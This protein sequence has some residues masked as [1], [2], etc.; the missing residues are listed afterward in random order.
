[1]VESVE[2]YTV[3]G[4]T[5]S[6]FTG[7]LEAYF[8]AKGLPYRF[9]EMDM[10]DF[11]KCAKATGIAQ[12]PQ[13]ETPQGAWLTDTTAIIKRL[14]EEATGPRLH[15]TDPATRFLS[16]LLEDLFDE[17]YWRPALYYRWAFDQDMQLMSS[18]IANTLL[19]DMPLPFFFRR[20]FILR[21]QR[22]V[23]LKQDGVTRT[24]APHI[25]AL[26]LNALKVL[27][28]VFKKRPFLLGDR[29]C[30]ADFGLMGPFFRHFF[31]DPTPAWIMRREA[32]H[33]AHWVTRMWAL[34]P[35]DIK[36]ASEIETIPDD[37]GYFFDLFGNEY[38]PYLEANADACA[39]GRKNIA[40]TANA[41]AWDLPTAPY[42]VHCLNELKSAFMAL[43]D[44]GKE[45]VSATIGAAQCARL[46]V[47]ATPIVDNKHK[48]VRDRLLR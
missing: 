12:M 6:Y 7:K 10:R 41:V 40:Y 21:R 32:P 31:S 1:M 22:T 44:G 15:S 30:E 20:Q 45:K 29:P 46:S 11:R 16:L 27:E 5:L 42:R 28:P 18:Q 39:H 4:L 13:V 23:F 2:K 25:E 19:R 37:L 26:Y 17:W 8:R 43:D 38:L 9:V 48:P 47:A 3:H 35:N 24:T 36:N 34:T 14:E 33:I